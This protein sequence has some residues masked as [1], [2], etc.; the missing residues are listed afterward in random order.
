VCVCMCVYVGMCVFVCV[1]IVGLTDVGRL[2]CLCVC[3][4]VGRAD[5]GAA[6]ICGA[7]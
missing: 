1:G 5:V 7:Q 2:V 3:V 4:F 6:A